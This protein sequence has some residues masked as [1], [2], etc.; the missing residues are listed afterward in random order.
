[1]ATSVN[2]I[3]DTRMLYVNGVGVPFRDVSMFRANNHRPIRA[4][5]LYPIGCG[6]VPEECK[7]KSPDEIVGH[8]SLGWIVAVKGFCH[9][10]E[11]PKNSVFELATAEG[12]KA[13]APMWIKTRE[14]GTTT[15]VHLLLVAGEGTQP[16]LPE[17]FQKLE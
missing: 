13:F 3:P 15:L 4:G 7:G 11:L 9:V 5:D 17:E 12:R 1:M 6:P 10:R 16:E 8:L 14:A 2:Q